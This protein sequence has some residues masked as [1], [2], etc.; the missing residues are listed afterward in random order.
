MLDAFPDIQIVGEAQNLGQT[1]DLVIDKQP[2]VV[3]LDIQLGS[4]NGFDLFE[5]IEKS[6]DLI[7]VTAF[8]EFA[9]RAFEINALDYLLKPVNPERLEK[10]LDRL[11]VAR[12]EPRKSELRKLEIDDRLFVEINDRCS[13]IK[14]VDIAFIGASGD[15]SEVHTKSGKMALMD[16]S[17]RDWESRLPSKHFVRIHR[18][19]IVNMN[20]IDKI[21][22]LFNRTM[23]V[24]IKN[25][26]EPFTA[27]RRYAAKL[28]ANFG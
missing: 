25:V 17:L 27:S 11:L 7:F 21:E 28:R 18:S 14:I 15:Y 26:S 2:D 8:D 5:K 13:F 3:F 9:I 12:K 20:E 22:T 4:E 24:H 6:F 16:Y 10:A 23:E 19:T 1:V